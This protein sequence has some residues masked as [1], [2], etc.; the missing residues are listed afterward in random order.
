MNLSGRRRR[1]THSG[2]IDGDKVPSE[3]FICEMRLS[4]DASKM[5]VDSSSVACVWLKK[6]NDADTTRRLR[7][8]EKSGNIAIFFF[9]YSNLDRL[10]NSRNWWKAKAARWESSE[11]KTG[12]FYSK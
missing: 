12:Q 10:K 9:H 4:V 5:N 3:V 1:N 7:K 6:N 11:S 2:L 8:L